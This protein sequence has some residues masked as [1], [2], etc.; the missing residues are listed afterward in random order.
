M[1]IF[2]ELKLLWLTG[3]TSRLVVAKI[4]CMMEIALIKSPVWLIPSLL[5]SSKFLS[6]AL[7]TGI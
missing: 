2:V 6:R 3:I 1:F 5:P 4:L 7:H